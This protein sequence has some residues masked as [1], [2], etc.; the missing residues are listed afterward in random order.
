MRIEVVIATIRDNSDRQY[1]GR[2]SRDVGAFYAPL[3]R[4][5]VV[6]PVVKILYKPEAETFIADYA[7]SLWSIN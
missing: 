6:C 3:L 2:S 1:V 7:E 4:V 5:E